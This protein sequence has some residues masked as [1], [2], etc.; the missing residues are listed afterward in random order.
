MSTFAVFLWLLLPAQ[1]AALPQTPSALVGIWEGIQR[2][3]Q[4]GDCGLAGT[5]N[6]VKISVMV[7]PD[8]S[9]RVQQAGGASEL[10][11]TGRI[12]DG[13]VMFEVPSKARCDSKS[14]Y[15]M[16]R[17]AGDFPTIKGGHRRLTLRGTDEP[18]PEQG[19]RFDRMMILTWKGPLPEAGR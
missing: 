16:S 18:C 1:D 9:L 17:Y 11:W 14:G 8:G 12:G 7:D 2:F 19:C 5:S 6:R 4:V 13:K 10:D 15:R 3:E